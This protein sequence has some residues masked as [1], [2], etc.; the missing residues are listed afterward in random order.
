MLVEIEEGYELVPP[1]QVKAQSWPLDGWQVWTTCCGW[2]DAT[3]PEGNAVVSRGGIVRRKMQPMTAP[4]G[5][6][7]RRRG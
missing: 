7:E 6:R 1:E 2:V 4:A 3:N 5:P